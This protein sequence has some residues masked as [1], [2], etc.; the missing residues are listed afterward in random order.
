MRKI[1]LASSAMLV[2]TAGAAFAQSSP[3]LPSASSGQLL[4]A[5]VASVAGFGNN[6]NSQ[7]AALPGPVAVPTPGT[8]VVRLGGRVHVEAGAGWSSLDSFSS[9]ASGGVPT[10]TAAGR[11][12]PAGNTIT[13]V[14]TLGAVTSISPTVAAVRA[15][16]QA[17][18]LGTYMRLYPGLDAMATNGLRYGAGTEIRTNFT[19]SFNQGGSSQTNSQTLFVRRAFVYLAGDNWGLLR[20]G[21]A[22]GIIGLFDGGVTTGQNWSNSGV[23]NGGD[24]STVN[25]SRSTIPFYWL[26]LAGNEY[27][28]PKIVYI[29]PK[30]AGFSAGVALVPSQANLYNDGGVSPFPT[31]T[32][33]GA[34]TFTTGGVSCGVVGSGC[35]TLSSSNNTVDAF[36]YR[37]LYQAGVQ[38]LNDIGPVNVRAYAVYLGSG[39]VAYTGPA[40][41]LS[42]TNVNGAL[43]YNNALNVGNFGVA[44]TFAGFTAAAN[45]IGGAMNGQ[46]GL[47]PAGAPNLNATTASLQYV[48]GPLTLGVTGAVADSQG[49]AALTGY[50]QLHEYEFSAGGR[51][52]VAPGLAISADYIYENRK[53]NGFNFATNAANPQSTGSFNNRNS[54]IHGQAFLLSVAV[55][56]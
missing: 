46:L 24:A 22:D 35:S 17:Y 6:N 25:P 29:T 39:Q 36:R 27:G 48:T 45:Y 2:A 43:F 23:F 37:N 26:S 8:F 13:N 4:S 18:G 49:S 31:N 3:L 38:Y 56:W 54:E 47:K 55:N 41:A 50:S 53:Q 34:T 1:L 5:P 16:K 42:A 51:Y 21:Q 32:T 20:V 11:T 7:A 10:I 28:T 30:L 19:S 44:A 15:K 33:F 14:S 40:G 52:V 12:I 9:P